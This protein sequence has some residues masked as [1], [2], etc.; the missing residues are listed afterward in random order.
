MQPDLLPIAAVCCPLQPVLLP[1]AAVCC[2]GAAVA[3]YQ[4]G[5]QCRRGPAPDFQSA[6]VK[7]APLWELFSLAWP[8]MV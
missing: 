8:V 1:L 5:L 7:K 2:P 6:H 3:P 4:A